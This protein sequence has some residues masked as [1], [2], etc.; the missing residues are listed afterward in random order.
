MRE[1][2][3]SENGDGVNVRGESLTINTKKMTFTFRPNG[4]R[5][6]FT[7]DAKAT[8]EEGQAFSIEADLSNYLVRSGE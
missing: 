5:V 1:L 3:P 4:H 2:I 8:L 6:N 7:E